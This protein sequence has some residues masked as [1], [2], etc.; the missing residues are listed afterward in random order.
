MPKRRFKSMAYMNDEREEKVLV[1]IPAFNES[2]NIINVV[3]DILKAIPPDFD[4]LVI[5]D[6]QKT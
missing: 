4:L 6:G 3:N 5:D 1:C 2:A